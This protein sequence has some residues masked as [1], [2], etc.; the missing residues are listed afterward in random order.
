MRE[1]IVVTLVAG[2]IGGVAGS[3]GAAEKKF[4]LQATVAAQYPASTGPFMGNWEGKWSEEEDKDPFLGAQII[5]LGKDTYRINLLP[6]IDHRCEPYAVV[7]VKVKDNKLTFKQGKYYGT[8]EEGRFTGG[9]VEDDPEDSATF[10][11]KRVIKG[12]P[13]LGRTPPEN[14]V[15]LFDGTSL[16]AWSKPEKTGWGIVDGALMPVDPDADELVS[17]GKF[18]DVEMHVEFRT[19]FLPD[20]RGQKRGNSGVFLQDEYEIQVLDSFGL[21]GYF[22]ECGAFYKVSAP[23]VNMCRPP[24]EWQTYDVIFTAPKFDENGKQTAN[25]R[26]TV[27]HNGKLIHTDEEIPMLPTNSYDDRIKPHPKAPGNI[28]L[29]SH[30]NHVQY[31]NIWLVE[32]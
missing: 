26:M 28:R 30:G 32:R 15:I 17:K 5:A 22:R 4:D 21:P 19:P 18:K 16:D 12:S 14:A 25:A 3:A 24:T 2:L 8:V 13:T 23:K 9:K 7:D 27:R 11:M 6:A 1:F 20:K 29:Q 31:R 10:E